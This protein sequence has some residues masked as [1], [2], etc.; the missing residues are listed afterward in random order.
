VEE[1]LKLIIARSPN[2][3]APA[4]QCM[5]ALR[6]N[7]PVLAQ[8]YNQVCQMAFSDPAAEFSAAERAIISDAL[9]VSPLIGGRPTTLT[10]RLGD[11]ERTQISE[12]AEAAGM[13]LSEYARW[14]LLTE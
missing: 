2:A 13:S 4:L 1:A 8:R 10:V 7:S 5:Q 12:A 9:S 3:A 6:I 14:R 11:A